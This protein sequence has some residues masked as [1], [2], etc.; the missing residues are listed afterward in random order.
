VDNLL[1]NQELQYLLQKI[2]FSQ[3]NGFNMFWGIL[4]LENNSRGFSS[5]QKEIV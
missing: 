5:K 3:K 4:L 1:Q 2:T